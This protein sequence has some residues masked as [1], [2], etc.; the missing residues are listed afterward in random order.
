MN[1]QTENAEAVTRRFLEEFN[2]LFHI[3]AKDI[4]PQVHDAR[5]A[6]DHALQFLHRCLLL[7]FIMREGWSEDDQEFLQVLRQ[8]TFSLSHER[9]EQVCAFF[10]RYDFTLSE[11]GPLDVE[12]TIDPEMIGTVYENLVN[13][14]P[15]SDERGEA[16]IFYTPRPETA[17]MCR[18]A[19]VDNLA[20]NLG[21]QH[22]DTFYDAVF[23]LDPHEKSTSDE[24][25]SALR[26][27]D[28]L[29]TYLKTVRVL[30]PSCGSGSFLVC[31][32]HVLDGLQERANR[33]CG[34]HETPS[35]RKKHI[36]ERNLYGVD[37][38]EWAICVTEQRLWL[39]L[40]AN[41]PVDVRHKTVSGANI[42]PEA[43]SS[44]FAFQLRCA[45]SLVQ[46][47]PCMDAREGELAGFD[48]I[49]GNPPYVRQ[50]KIGDPFSTGE[51]QHNGAAVVD[52][53]ARLANSIYAAFP[54]FFGYQ[55]REG[56]TERKLNAQSD[57]YIYFFL[58]SLR[59][60]NSRGTLCFITSN[61]WLDVRYGADLQEFLLRYCRVHMI[62]DNQIKRSFA[63][64]DINT[65]IML[66]SAPAAEPGA[67]EL[68]HI[69]RFVMLN[70]AFEQALT[71]DI[72]QAIE[73]SPKRVT[74]PAWR[75]HPVCQKVL[76]AEGYDGAAG[77]AKT[78]PGEMRGTYTV[79]NWSGKYLRAPDIYWT[80]L[81]KGR[82]KLVQL[83]NIA[84]IRRGITTGANDFF[85]L[86]RTKLLQWPIE[87][88][89]LRPALR[90][91]RECKSITL[92]PEM[93]TLKL[94]L[95][96]MTKEELA[97]TVAREYIEWGEAQQYHRRPTC[98]GRA[99]WWDLGA[100][101]P[102]RLGFNYL[103]DATAKTFYSPGGCYCS[104]NFQEITAP[105]HLVLPLCAVLNSTLF[106]LMINVA[107]RANFGGGLLKIQTYELAHL[108]CLH[109][110]LIPPDLIA[111][112]DLAGIFASS[113]WDVLA[114]SPER[115]MLDTMLFDVLELTRGERDAVYEAVI[116]MVRRRIKKAGQKG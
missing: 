2:R 64:A 88:D 86:D 65:A 106:Q 100:H 30:D 94:F 67:A 11:T 42:S 37:V 9:I 77:Q 76:L 60:L 116:E 85:Y 57:L 82:E 7:C 26:L 62:V 40:L 101:S 13:A 102:T 34:R 12:E 113:A 91:P 73:H 99:R 61:S 25:L 36:V 109:P 90:S 52:Y 96:P 95:C 28:Q 81:E 80:L 56:R 97:G 46:D 45:D 54:S 51:Q 4:L 24:T 70:V 92:R 59:L 8:E 63:S 68:E 103:V 17:L 18:L 83:G 87:E 21:Q 47:A 72:F 38:K 58:T 35:V 14:S 39:A 3:L 55:K 53:K 32:L 78:V 31:M 66:C 33:H 49:I 5:Q 74:T 104:D 89:F 84:E 115:R 108:L 105:A 114:P 6:H 29:D 48:I 23:A 43:L 50:E 69:T 19:L 20:S 75:V 15:G 44:H 93:L 16:G 98:A 22:R 10:Q 1:K 112:V 27:W 107:G 111:S 110:A 41:T 71:P 79:K